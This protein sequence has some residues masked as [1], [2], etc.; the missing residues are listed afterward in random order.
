MSDSGTNSE[1]N[2]QITPKTEDEYLAMLNIAVS[3]GNDDEVNRLMTTN[4]TFTSPDAT[5]VVEEPVQ[6]GDEP[7]DGDDSDPAK[8]D[9]GNGTPASNPTGAADD[10]ANDRVNE[11]VTQDPPQQQPET[12]AITKEELQLLKSAAGRVDSLQSRLHQLESAQRNVHVAKKVTEQTS[13]PTTDVDNKIKEQLQALKEV[14]PST[15][16]LLEAMQ[17][18]FD[19]Q[20]EQARAVPTLMA[21]ELNLRQQ[22]ARLQEEFNKVL[23]VHPDFDSIRRHVAWAA[24]KDTLTDAQREWAESS[25]ADQVVVAVQQF[26][27]QHGLIPAEPA[28]PAAPVQ[29]QAPAVPTVPV[30][31]D[32][33]TIARQRKL[34]SAAT[35]RETS[36]KATQVFDPEAAFKEEYDKVLKS[37]GL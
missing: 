16:E 10:A 25:N 7:A 24:W 15:A 32:Q 9:D 34:E 33:A 18:R 37:L 8:V 5:E 35:G 20:L 4:F 22:E 26:K 11:P 30:V 19:A 17:A 27:L 21:E 2:S 12:V 36:I 13:K 31:Q 28:A 1:N 29:Q 23:T 6:A 14:D 3:E